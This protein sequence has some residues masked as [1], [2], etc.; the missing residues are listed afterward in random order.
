VATLAGALG[1]G[2]T[3]EEAMTVANAAG[4]IVVGKRGTATIDLK[5]LVA[6]FEGLSAD[7]QLADCQGSAPVVNSVEC[8]AL[9]RRWASEG[10]KVGFTN[11]CFD[12]VHPGHVSLVEQAAAACDRLILALNTD[13]SVQRLKGPT[14]PIQHEDARAAVVAGLKGVSAVI[15]FDESTPAKLIETLVPDVLVKGADYREDE[16][17]GAD[18]VKANGGKVVLAQLIDGQSTT[19]IVKKMS[20]EVA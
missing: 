11:G 13:A 6:E 14:R 5:E 15:L 18:I 16:V 2:L 9:R 20:G 3:V 17:V 10:L 12:I 8:L 7:A 1:G 19:R 4:A